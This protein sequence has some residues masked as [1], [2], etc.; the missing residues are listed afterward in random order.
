MTIAVANSKSNPGTGKSTFER[1]PAQ[2]AAY[3]GAPSSFPK[4]KK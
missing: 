3:N 2:A 1:T 4:G